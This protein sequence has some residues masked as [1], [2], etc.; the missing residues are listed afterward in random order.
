MRHRL[1]QV[2]G[3]TKNGCDSHLVSVSVLLCNSL[4]LRAPRLRV[5]RPLVARQEFIVSPLTRVTS[6]I[7]RPM[8][9]G[10]L[11]RLWA[12]GDVLVGEKQGVLRVHRYN[13]S[14]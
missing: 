13:M 14:D 6:S 11:K 4:V 9:K 7:I 8:L 2:G 5:P 10:E 12:Y 3:S 1:N